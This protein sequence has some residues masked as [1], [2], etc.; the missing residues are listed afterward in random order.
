MK[1]KLFLLVFVAAGG[2]WA[3]IVTVFAAVDGFALVPYLNVP[4][5]GIALGTFGGWLIGALGLR[6]YYK[7]DAQNAIRK[8]NAMV[9]RR[10]ATAE[11]FKLEPF[12]HGHRVPYFDPRG[13]YENR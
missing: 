7:V 8:L 12:Q 13:N 11:R 2:A 6:M 9:P 5:A 4:W 3:L 1:A 10:P